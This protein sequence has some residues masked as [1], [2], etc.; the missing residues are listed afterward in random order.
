MFNF[1][2]QIIFFK[3]ECFGDKK[4]VKKINEFLS[5]FCWICSFRLGKAFY[6]FIGWFTP[7]AKN[8]KVILS[9]LL[10]LL[11]LYAYMQIL[12]YLKKLQ[13]C[14]KKTEILNTIPLG[15]YILRQFSHLSITVYCQNW[16]FWRN[17]IYW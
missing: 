14:N 11:T 1:C 17:S 2:K 4:K 12:T 8:S 9:S 5:I 15:I 3:S 16:Q 7:P 10:A 13:F 6:P